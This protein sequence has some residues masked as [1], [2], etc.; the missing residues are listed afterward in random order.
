MFVLGICLANP[1][2][3][4]AN[5]NEN[6]SAAKKP[7]SLEAFILGLGYFVTAPNYYQHFLNIK[8][9]AQY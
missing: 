7:F 4:R 8:Y 1:K 9:F 2:E 3:G 5:N 6:I